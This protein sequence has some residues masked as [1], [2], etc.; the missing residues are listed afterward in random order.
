MT[1][2]CSSHDWRSGDLSLPDGD[3]P[4]GHL[5]VWPYVPY[6]DDDSDIPGANDTHGTE[7]QSLTSKLCENSSL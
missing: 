1:G 3:V 2:E 6:D 5:F 4:R 7:K